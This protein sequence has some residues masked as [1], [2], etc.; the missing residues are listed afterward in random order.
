MLGRDTRWRQGALVIDEDALTLGLVGERHTNKRAVVISHDC[1]LPN[2]SEALVEVIVGSMVE[3]LDAMLTGARNPRR[4]H[5]R[6]ESDSGECVIIELRHDDLR[7]IEK[8]E[9]AALNGCDESLALPDDEKRALKQWL[10]ARYARPAFP[11]AFEHRLRKSTGKRNVEQEI[12][13][14]IAPVS[15]HLVGLFVDLGSERNVELAEGQPYFLRIVV[16]YDAL[17]GGHNARTM[18]E[19][20]AAQLQDLFEK[21]YGPP[22]SASDIALESCSALADTQITLADLRRVD[23]WRVEYLSFR[24]DPV[25][26]FLGAGTLPT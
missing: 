6:Y 18:T 25:G 9:F 5:I 10:A 22:D 24:E 16:V 15:H 11:N 19:S 26:D 12:A 2:E 3:R 7:R 4:L 23:Q 21:A 8:S 17:E 1:D 14:I 20:V 13:K